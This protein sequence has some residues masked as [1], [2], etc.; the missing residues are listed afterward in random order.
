M[1]MLIPAQILEILQ[2]IF[3]TVKLSS[4]AIYYL[5]V[6]ALYFQRFPHKGREKP[7][8]NKTNNEV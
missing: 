1:Q 6:C 2:S 3:F 5:L 7:I 4:C 8:S